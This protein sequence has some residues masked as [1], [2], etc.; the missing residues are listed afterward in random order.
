MTKIWWLSAIA[1]ISTLTDKMSP[2]VIP[3]MYS[4]QTLMRM[5]NYW[6]NDKNSTFT[7]FAKNSTTPVCL[8]T[9]S[10]VESTYFQMCN[11]PCRKNYCMEHHNKI[12][13]SKRVPT[14]SFALQIAKSTLPAFTHRDVSSHPPHCN[15]GGREW[16]SEGWHTAAH[17]LRRCWF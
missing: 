7:Y 9:Y 2:N 14:A 13:P 3:T 12:P 1:F 6:M 15:E 11:C 17:D 5:S 8:L 4:T 10:R 16:V